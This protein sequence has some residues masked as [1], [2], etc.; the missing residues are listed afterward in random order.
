M[1]TMTWAYMPFLN[2]QTLS[3]I[4]PDLRHLTEP[5]YLEGHSDTKFVIHL[6]EPAKLPS[7]YIDAINR[8]T[9]CT[10]EIVHWYTPNN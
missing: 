1:K 4:I 5:A 10:Y 6:L 2:F 7:E 3:K 8:G 9:N